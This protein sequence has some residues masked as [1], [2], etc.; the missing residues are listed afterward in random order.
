[1]GKFPSREDGQEE[2]EVTCSATSRE[3]LRGLLAFNIGADL[4]AV[5]SHMRAVP[6]V[7]Q[8]AVVFIHSHLSVIS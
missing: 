6:T 1:M 5:R 2:E 7:G 8:G 4:E 3:A